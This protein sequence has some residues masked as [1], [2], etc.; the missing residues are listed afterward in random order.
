MHV[1]CIANDYHVSIMFWKI[2]VSSKLT[3]AHWFYMYLRSFSSLACVLLSSPRLSHFHFIVYMMA[4]IFLFSEVVD[5]LFLSAISSLICGHCCS[6]LLSVPLPFWE[7]KKRWYSPFFSVHQRSFSGLDGLP[8]YLSSLEGRGWI[9][10]LILFPFLTFACLVLRRGS[11]K[12]S[13]V[14]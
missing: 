3:A 9:I 14:Q 5:R 10:H 13:V 4:R 12:M 11:K 7:L 6:V 8:N 1:Q 2:M